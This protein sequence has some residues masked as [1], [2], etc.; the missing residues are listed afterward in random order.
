MDLYNARLDV[1]CDGLRLAAGAW[2]PPEPKGIV[3]FLHGMPSAALPAPGVAGYPDLAREWAGY[4]WVAVW[5]DLRSV[6]ESPGFFSIE[7]WVRD[8]AAVIEAARGIEGAAEL[9]L[10]VVATSAGGAV[11]TEAIRRGAPVSAL[12]L[13]AAPAEWVGFAPNPEAAVERAVDG[14]GLSLA[15]DVVADPTLWAAEFQGVA[16][17]R[18][19]AELRIP[20][21]IIHGTADAVIPAAH[22]RRIADRSP[23]AELWVIEGAEHNLRHDRELM[24]R[25]GEWLTR[26]LGRRDPG[27]S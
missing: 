21:L 14:S 25:V 19:I 24:V 1:I 27:A 23:G 7:G 5:A 10:A 8:A 18:S 15:P 9:P 13:L 11:G 22:A 2:M 16:T 20:V 12:V 26:G 3:V 17:E 6:R 4:G